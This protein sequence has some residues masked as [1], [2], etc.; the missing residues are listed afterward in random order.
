MKGKIRLLVWITLCLVVVPMPLAQSRQTTTDSTEAKPAQAEEDKNP[1]I[2]RALALLGQALIQVKEIPDTISRVRSYTAAAEALWE[3]DQPR[4]CELLRV[5]VAETSQARQSKENHDS[6]SKQRLDQLMAELLRRLSR[7]DPAWAS[8]LARSLK[9]L[10]EGEVKAAP[11]SQAGPLTRSNSQ[12]A[13]ALLTLAHSLIDSDPDRAI[14]LA[15]ESL[16]DGVTPSLV[17]FLF[18]I[19]SQKPDEADRLYNLALATARRPTPSSLRQLLLLGSYVLPN[20]P[21]PIQMRFSGAQ[22]SVN[23]AQA[24]RYLN[25]LLETLVRIQ[26]S[27]VPAEAQPDPLL[28]PAARYSLLQQLHPLVA[29]YAPEKL[30]L[31]EALSQDLSR[32]VPQQRRQAIETGLALRTDAVEEQLETLLSQ[33]ER[34]A[35]LKRRGGLFAHAAV[36]AV[37]SGKIDQ[38]LEILPRLNDE[39]VRSHLSELIHYE[40]VGYALRKGDLET[41]RRYALGLVNPEHLTLSLLSIARKFIERKDKDAALVTLGEAE[42]QL[43]KL[44]VSAEKACSLLRL[45]EVMTAAD[46]SR[47][48]DMLQAAVLMFNKV[49]TGLEADAPR[50]TVNTEG[51][52]TMRILA[53]GDL[54]PSLE[55]I[56]DSLGSTDFDRALFVAVQWKRVDIRVM[57]EI[58]IARATLRKTE[59]KPPPEGEGEM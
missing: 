37:K 32:H 16:S 58:A 36:T 39:E 33:A 23:S 52:N 9:Q 7:L 13:E 1:L 19:R 15:A 3:H 2:E 11:K 42:Q 57:A 17:L 50:I 5:A 21:L 20:R 18:R 59:R 43:G 54:A 53:S 44:Q 4:A 49:D 51:F 34:T 22:S 8:E 6:S 40:G 38:A 48:F 30:A 31:V 12:Q 10:E 47:A 29:Q 26:P 56:M 46:P 25:L 28:T 55:K 45:T 14:R 41:A 35:D 24:E 27:T